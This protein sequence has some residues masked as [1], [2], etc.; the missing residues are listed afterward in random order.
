MGPIRPGFA[1]STSKAAQTKPSNSGK[2]TKIEDFRG[3]SGF[4]QVQYLVLPMAGSEIRDCPVYVSYV[5]IEV[6]K[7]AMK[8]SADRIQF[9]SAEKKYE[10]PQT[11]LHDTLDDI[12]QKEQSLRAKEA[13]LARPGLTRKRLRELEAEIKEAKDK[14][15]RCE[16]I[17]EDFPVPVLDDNSFAMWRAGAQTIPFILL[18]I[19]N[20]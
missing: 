10:K 17:L 7:A 2:A 6:D 1:A 9:G 20:Q 8:E 15:Q 13:E 16:E 19:C 18:P 12:Q 5:K 11:K 4:L 3:T 14:I